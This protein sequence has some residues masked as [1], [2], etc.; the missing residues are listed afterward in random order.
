MKIGV[1]NVSDGVSSYWRY[2]AQLIQSLVAWMPSV[3]II[4]F[5]DER[6]PVLAGVTSIVRH[7]TAPLS[8]ALARHYAA[9][10]G[11]WFFLDSDVRVQR[12]V[13]HVFDAPAFD[14]AVASR[15]GTLSVGEAESPFMRRM[16]Y[17]TGVVFSRRQPFWQAVLARTE[18][19]AVA[20]PFFGFQIAIND[21]IA[22]GE[23]RVRI[24]PA[25]YNYPPRHRGDG[26]G[27]AI[28]H[29]KG[30]RKRWLLEAA[31]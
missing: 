18:A 1:Y 15:A 9:C 5:S 19:L 4:Q 22:M 6:S 2:G 23:F 7:Q 31:A 27:A 16:P 21:T 26:V 12:D 14:V 8:L 24:L 28:L 10:D 29:F 17:N 30:P 25:T 20:E 3:E 11:E 13:Q